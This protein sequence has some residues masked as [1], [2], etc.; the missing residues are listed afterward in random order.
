MDV[1]V[2]PRL[3]K[4]TQEVTEFAQKL[5][6][7]KLLL[8]IDDLGSVVF[9]LT[10]TGAYA[11]SMTVNQLGDTSG[12]SVSSARRQRGVDPTSFVQAM[13]DRLYDKL[14][15]IDLE[16]GATFVNNAPHAQEVENNYDVFGRL[17]NILR[18]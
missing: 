9:N 18:G 17:G 5:L 3:T 7:N 1:S 11:E 2:S 12:P 10:D 6:A 14:Q 4:K 15:I 8:G 16:Q 13:E